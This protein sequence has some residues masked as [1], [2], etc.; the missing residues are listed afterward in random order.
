[1][2]RHDGFSDHEAGARQW[3][4]VCKMDGE[5]ALIESGEQKQQLREISC[6][7]KGDDKNSVLLGCDTVWTG[8]H[9]TSSNSSLA[10]Q[11]AL[12]F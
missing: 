9:S 6:C 4:L 11:M 1:V 2:P 5:L 10:L 3:S 7:Q 12:L 8:E